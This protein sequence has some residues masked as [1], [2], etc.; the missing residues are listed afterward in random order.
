MFASFAQAHNATKVPR[1][2]QQEAIRAHY[3]TVK[4]YFTASD[5][6]KLNFMHNR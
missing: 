5:E 6:I 4:Y 2:C 1:A 3:D